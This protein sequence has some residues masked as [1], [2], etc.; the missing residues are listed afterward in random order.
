MELTKETLLASSEINEVTNPPKFALKQ[1]M[2]TKLDIKSVLDEFVDPEFPAIIN[3]LNGMLEEAW[4]AKSLPRASAP[5]FRETTADKTGNRAVV[6]FNSA[7]EGEASA[8]VEVLAAQF[9]AENAAGY[10]VRKSHKQGGERRAEDS[11][12]IQR[13]LTTE[14][15][16]RIQALFPQ[17]PTNWFEMDKVAKEIEATG[18]L[19]VIRDDE[20]LK[21]LVYQP[22]SKSNFME[23]EMSTYQ[24]M[25]DEEH[26][27]AEALSEV[28]D[29]S[30]IVREYFE[31][32]QGVESREPAPDELTS[33]TDVAGFTIDF[34]NLEPLCHRWEVIFSDGTT[35]DLY[36]P[37][38]DTEAINPKTGNTYDP[39]TIARGV[40]FSYSA[41]CDLPRERNI[42]DKG[43]H[44]REL[45]AM[46]EEL[47]SEMKTSVI[48][49]LK[50][51]S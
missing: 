9:L 12:W 29:V 30:D 5:T 20:S 40:W 13:L 50:L 33:Y 15:Q 22:L 41:K 8:E 45:P 19:G 26:Y 36:A 14:E 25:I 16:G 4:A 48:G 44:G 32:L 35:R 21:I 2:F 42:I 18:L 3:N 49:A 17:R 27:L 11:L 6:S 31:M 28:G 7:V 51:F 34:E 46:V 1:E 39:E 24:Q 23:S 10:T 37:K 47:E 43:L 38:L